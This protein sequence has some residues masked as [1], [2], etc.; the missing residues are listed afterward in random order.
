VKQTYLLCPPS[1]AL[2]V[3]ALH[4]DKEEGIAVEYLGQLARFVLCGPLGEHAAVKV[5]DFVIEPF[6]WPETLD[7]CSV[8]FGGSA[9]SLEEPITE[10]G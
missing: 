3:L 5:D 4:L 7:R 2:I 1:K 6:A 8:H 9:S 10:S